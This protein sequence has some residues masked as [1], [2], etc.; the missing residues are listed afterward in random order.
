MRNYKDSRSFRAKTDVLDAQYIHEFAIRHVDDLRPWSPPSAEVRAV[1]ELLG[2]RHAASKALM[3]LRQTCSE[4]HGFEA[5]QKALLEMVKGLEE[6]LAKF[7]GLDENYWRM[8]TIPGVGPLAAAALTY[9][10]AVHS[11]ESSDAL[12]AFLGLDLRVNDSG[13]HRG[14]RRLSKR[15][16]PLLRRLV[17]CAGWSLLRTKLAKDKALSLK[18]QKRHH[19]ERMVIAGRKILRAAYALNA[20]KNTFDSEKWTW[21]T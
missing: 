7:A 9:L 6:S 21:Q 14:R 2:R 10:F 11:F 15:G 13:L 1:R 5:V 18:A 16:D 12:V 17:T 20:T 4:V 19:P 8:Q 3:Q